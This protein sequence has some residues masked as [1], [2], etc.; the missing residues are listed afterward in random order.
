MLCKKN[1]KASS[2]FAGFFNMTTFVNNNK[3]LLHYFHKSEKHLEQLG[4]K[5]NLFPEY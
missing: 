4:P 5:L 2:F 3:K 1:E